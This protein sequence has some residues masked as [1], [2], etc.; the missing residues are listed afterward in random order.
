MRPDAPPD[1]PEARRVVA[2]VLAGDADAFRVLVE[3]E[4]RSIVRACYR[5]LGDLHEAEDAAQ[6][7]FVTAYRALGTW[8]GEGSFGAWLARI[9]TRIAVRRAGRRRPV[10]WIDP[11]PVS[12]EPAGSGGRTGPGEAALVAALG[13]TPDPAQ[14]AV[15]A[16]RAAAIRT[17]VVGLDEP[18][19]EVVV[20]RFFSDLSL[21]EIA[22]QSGRP[23]G[24][25]KTHLHRGLQRL[26]RT[27]EAEGVA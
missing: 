10:A 2:A 26:R 23:L 13:S 9:A 6:E 22:A 3:R 25:V 19:R 27:L 18:Y 16:E 1:D 17:A 8:R 15:R 20:L 7:A 4:S 14:L 21:A 5:V 24:T 12:H 11:R